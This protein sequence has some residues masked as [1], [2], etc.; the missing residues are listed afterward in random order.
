MRRISDIRKETERLLRKAAIKIKKKQLSRA[1]RKIKHKNLT[2][3]P[4]EKLK[5]RL[6]QSPPN[7]IKSSNKIK[8]L[9]VPAGGKPGYSRKKKRK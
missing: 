6:L 9:S 1:K 4:A 7:P 3:K 8:V 2:E 5:Q